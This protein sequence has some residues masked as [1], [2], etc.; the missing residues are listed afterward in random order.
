MINLFVFAYYLHSWGYTAYKQ[1]GADTGF[2]FVLKLYVSL[3]L[4]FILPRT[5]QCMF[6]LYVYAGMYVSRYVLCIVHFLYESFR[7]PRNWNAYVKHVFVM[8]VCHA[9]LE[10]FLL[11][12]LG[13]RTRQ[14]HGL[15]SWFRYGSHILVMKKQYWVQFTN[16]VFTGYFIPI[17]MSPYYFYAN[18]IF[19]WCSDIYVLK[20]V[21]GEW[22]SESQSKSRFEQCLLYPVSSCPVCFLH[23]LSFVPFLLLSEKHF[24]IALFFFFFFKLASS[25]YRC[26]SVRIKGIKCAVPNQHAAFSAAYCW[27]QGAVAELLQKHKSCQRKSRP[28]H[29]F[30]G[31]AYWKC[32]FHRGGLQFSPISPLIQSLVRSEDTEHPPLQAVSAAC[33]YDDLLT[34]TFGTKYPSCSKQP[35]EMR[36]MEVGSKASVCIL[37]VFAGQCRPGNK[38]DSWTVSVLPVISKLFLQGQQVYLPPQPPPR[39]MSFNITV[40]SYCLHCM[41]I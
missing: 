36:L 22:M 5:E 41:L 10:K 32:S 6:I 24:V 35:L 30:I 29:R 14:S 39:Y 25:Q 37:Q 17:I 20:Q 9:P 12:I 40:G 34:N 15:L 8:N 1:V 23:T 11:C 38:T 19:H 18:T 3:R 33:K 21:T 13:T 26:Q 31:Q 2:V 4:L 16:K 28:S 7:F 27:D